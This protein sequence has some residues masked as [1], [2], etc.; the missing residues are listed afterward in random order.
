M[1]LFDAQL[2]L[3]TTQEPVIIDA[4]AHHGHTTEQYLEVFPRA[5]IVAIEPDCT[6]IAIAIQR[7]E[8]KA[9]FIPM[10][11]SDRAGMATF[12]PVSHHGSHSLL[13]VEEQ[14]PYFDSPV[15]GLPPYSVKSTTLDIICKERNLTTV[16]I[17]KMDIQGSELLALRGSVGMLSRGAVRLIAS[18]VLFTPLYR[19]QP[20]FW[21]LA[22][23][24][25]P[26][27]YALQ[28]LYEEQYHRSNGAVLRWADAIFVS[29]YMQRI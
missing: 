12:R 28:G 9:E 25:R 8:G 27:G 7:L 15:T 6:N 24:L 23:F 14:S 19:N 2:S 3:L 20:S 29:P 13:E 1:N 17:L 22:D 10:A 4:G 11:L 16:D 26:H 18:E 21:D 5:R